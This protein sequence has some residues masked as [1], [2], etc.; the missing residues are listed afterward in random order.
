MAS[1]RR[2]TSERY[3]GVP[4]TRRAATSPDAA[5][6]GADRPVTPSTSARS[7]ALQRAVARAVPGLRRMEHA[8]RGARCRRRAGGARAARR[9]A[10]RCGA[11]ATRRRAAAAAR[12]RRGAGRRGCRPA[13]ASSTACSAAGSC[14]ARW[15]C[16]AARRG[17]A[18]RRSPTWCSATSQRAGQ[19][20]LYVS[21]EESAEQVRLRAE[22]LGSARAALTVPVLAET[23]LDTVLD[24][25]AAHAPEAC[26]IDSVQTLTRAELSGAPGSVGQ[27]REVAARI[28][29]LAKAPGD[30]RDP[31]RPR[32]QG[33]RARRPARARAPRRLRAAV[34]GRARAPLPR[35]ARAEEPLRL[36]QR[37]GPVRD[38]PGRPGRGA[39][40]LRALRRRGDTRARA[41]WC[42]R[43]WRAR[44]R[45]SS[46]S[47]RS[48]RP[49]SSSSR[50]GSSRAWTATA[51]RSC[52]RSSARHG[53]VR[54]GGADVF[55]NVVGGVRVDEPGCDL[56]VALAVASASRGVRRS[57]GTPRG[58]L[59]RARADR[60]AALGRPSRA[61]PG[62]GRQARPART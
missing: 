49:P 3:S 32:D 27:V 55:V 25:L 15:C 36:D 26:V 35:A 7:A 39:R 13:S 24:T 53:G 43:R 18:S 62:G 57:R 23:D 60:R 51:W 59:R 38:A 17:S 11:P 9:C 6:A 19:R 12:G 20:T 41:A 58:V 56:A 54:T 21:G 5:Y 4:P 10:Q 28:M 44:A 45:C 47:R 42:S 61:A 16:S 29:E 34:R 50:A 30:R 40:R 37:G 46:R 52:S 1:A 2:A 48:S 22:R 14:R 8:G 33:R 31:R